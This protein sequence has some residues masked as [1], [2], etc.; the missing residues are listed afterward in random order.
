[1]F[2]TQATLVAIS[3]SL[4]MLAAVSCGGG[5]PASLGD[6]GVRLTGQLSLDDTQHGASTVSGLSGAA[7]TA[8]DA[9]NGR[10]RSTA[11]TGADGSFE[12]Q[13]L[14]NGMVILRIEPGNTFVLSGIGSA[15]PIELIQEFDL[16][17]ATHMQYNGRLTLVDTD[18]DGTAD[19][20]LT[21][22]E[23]HADGGP[24]TQVDMREIMPD[25]QQVLVDSNGDGEVSDETPQEDADSDGIPDDVTGHMNSLH[26][27]MLRGPIEEI[28]SDSIT[29]EGI[30]FGI[31]DGTKF[32][33]KGNK[34]ADPSMFVAGLNVLIRG[35]W[36]GTE[37]IALEI[38]STG[39][40]NQPPPVSED[41]LTI[42]QFVAHID[43]IA[44]E[45]FVA[46][47][48]TFH[49]DGDTEW[50]ANGD[51]ATAGDFQVNDLVKAE[52]RLNGT[53]WKATEVRLL[54]SSAMSGLLLAQ[55]VGKISALDSSSVQVGG[56][57]FTLDTDSEWY[58]VDGSDAEAVDFAVGDRVIVQAETD[59]FSW[60][61][62]EIR[63]LASESDEL[64][65]TQFVGHLGDLAADSFTLGAAEVSFD[66]TTNWEDGD[67]E[68]QT[69]DG[70]AD[71]DIVQA[72]VVASGGGWQAIEVRMLEAGTG[73]GLMLAQFFGPIDDLI[74]GDMTVGGQLFTI[75]GDTEFY[76]AIGVP[77]VQAVFDA[78]DA[79]LVEGSTDG[80]GWHADEVKPLDK[81]SM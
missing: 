41:K 57:D 28:S 4:S 11:I 49:F 23:L 47:G 69:P 17:G 52:A 2:R 32:K 1:M 71:G 65:L 44:D 74:A 26:G 20:L 50:E 40:R 3:L 73:S 51:D 55:F 63:P 35:L 56:F 81:M 13:N 58:F 29:V 45:S 36:N 42:S 27:G 64:F 16:S 66:G 30:T 48:L 60:T 10:V 61:A 7:I 78:G 38:K 31:T 68:T 43:S 21:Q 12:L 53:V 62:H 6:N 24:S 76:S 54:E 19:S 15:D 18:G 77:A 5:S 79:V 72:I 34:Q 22:R 37:W 39:P 33:D 9:G 8:M 25:K 14:P 75:D 59:G 67:V 80:E 46:G 70:F